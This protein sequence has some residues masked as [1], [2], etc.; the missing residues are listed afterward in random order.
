[1]RRR[2]AARAFAHVAR[3]VQRA[4]QARMGFEP[5]S[6]RKID[7]AG[8]DVIDGSVSVIS[9]DWGRTAER[10]REAEQR[11]P[12]QAGRL[13]LPL[14]ANDRLA[15]RA[16]RRSGGNHRRGRAPPPEQFLED[17]AIVSRRGGPSDRHV[18]S[19]RTPLRRDRLRRRGKFRRTRGRQGEALGLADFRQIAPRRHGHAA[20]WRDRRSRSRRKRFETWQRERRVRSGRRGFEARHLRRRRRRAGQLQLGKQVGVD[21]NVAEGLRDGWRYGRR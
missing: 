21:D 16:G 13:S 7:G 19:G 9:G 12:A 14:L 15:D 3:I 5:R 8:R 10:R 6:V 2:R 1:M 17:V 11:A 4:P 20:D 18:G